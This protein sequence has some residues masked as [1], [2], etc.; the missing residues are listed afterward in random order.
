SSFFAFFAACRFLP[1]DFTT[2]SSFLIGECV[3]CQVGLPDP[4]PKSSSLLS[5]N[6]TTARASSVTSEADLCCYAP[7]TVFRHILVQRA[8]Q[9]GVFMQD[10]GAEGTANCALE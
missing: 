7:W 6:H 4:T 9:L 2:R 1:L 8:E 5:K 10:I 3:G